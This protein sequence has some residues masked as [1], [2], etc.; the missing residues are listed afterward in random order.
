MRDIEQEAQRAA[1][2]NLSGGYVNAVELY[3]SIYRAPT[4]DTLLREFQA[5]LG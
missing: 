5:Q 3:T 1:T 4:F 2:I